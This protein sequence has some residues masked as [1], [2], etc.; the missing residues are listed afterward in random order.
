[1]ADPSEPIDPATLDAYVSAS[2]TALA[3]PLAAEWR[4][5][6][7]ANLVVTLRMAKLL[8]D[9]PLPDDA[10]PAPVFRA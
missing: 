6:V 3:L 2:A 10:E 5:A 8:G 9:F 1:M 4:G 7:K